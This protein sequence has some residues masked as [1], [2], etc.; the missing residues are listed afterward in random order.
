MNTAKVVSWMANDGQGGLRPRG[1]T[2]D[3]SAQLVGCQYKGRLPPDRLTQTGIAPLHVAFL[4]PGEP[5]SL[6]FIG[7]NGLQ[8]IDAKI[9]WHPTA[10]R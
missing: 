2:A 7:T 8:L 10:S 1:A 6:L 3:L 9:R 5:P 4:T